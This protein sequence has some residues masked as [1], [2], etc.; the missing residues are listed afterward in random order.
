MI[1]AAPPSGFLGEP[2]NDAIAAARFVVDDPEDLV[3]EVDA[4]ARGFVFLADQYFAGW[5]AIVNG[6]VTPIM[7]AN[8]T[9]RLVEVPAGAV[10]VEFHYRPASVR[11][12]A[13]ISLLTLAVVVTILV[14][15][16]SRPERLC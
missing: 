6:Q 2:E 11:I 8:H 7:R 14:A 1:E 16:R 10:R 12:G 15:T 4:P 13:A 3:L 9:F 5:S